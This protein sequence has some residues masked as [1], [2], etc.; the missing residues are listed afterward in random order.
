M[1]RRCAADLDPWIP[2]RRAAELAAPAISREVL[3]RLAASRALRSRS[4]NGSWYVHRADV[5]RYLADDDFALAARRR[6][7]RAFSKGALHVA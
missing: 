2:L 1:A 6:Y 3:R 7:R 5:Q 4:I